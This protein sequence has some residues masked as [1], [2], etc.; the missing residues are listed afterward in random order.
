VARPEGNG[1]SDSKGLPTTWSTNKNI[2]WRAELPSWSGATP[3]IWGDYVFITSPSKT[4]P[5]EKPKNEEERRGGGRFGE[6]VR[7]FGYER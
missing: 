1:L 6:E 4:E 2:V 3:I 7:K 5:T